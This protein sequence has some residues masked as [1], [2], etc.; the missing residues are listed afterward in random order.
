MK[1]VENPLASVNPEGAFPALSEGLPLLL[2][3]ALSYPGSHS[4]WW[5]SFLI[6]WQHT[7]SRKKKKATKKVPLSWLHLSFLTWGMNCSAPDP[8]LLNI[9]NMLQERSLEGSGLIQGTIVS[10]LKKPEPDEPIFHL[11]SS[12][13]SL[14]KYSS[15]TEDSTETS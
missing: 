8:A 5:L 3:A 13:L 4:C 7:Q 14:C 15:P 11:M 10:H 9:Q 12:T 6:F 2:Q 1:R